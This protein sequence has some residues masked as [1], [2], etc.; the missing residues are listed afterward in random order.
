MSVRARSD[1]AGQNI[2]L[3]FSIFLDHALW[4]LD[5]LAGL[6]SLVNFLKQ[7]SVAASARLNP[8]VITSIV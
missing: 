3:L 5:K 7:V 4:R 2:P 6:A 8:T 1:Q